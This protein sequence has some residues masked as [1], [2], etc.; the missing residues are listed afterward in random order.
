[1]DTD[2]RLSEIYA[3][4][5][6]RNG[7]SQ[8]DIDRSQTKHKANQLVVANV[9]HRINMSSVGTTHVYYKTINW[10]SIDESSPP[11]INTHVLICMKHHYGPIDVWHDCGRC[12]DD[13]NPIDSAVDFD[14]AT[15]K[16]VRENQDRWAYDHFPLRLVSSWG[17]DNVCIQFHYKLDM[18]VD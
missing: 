14:E 13:A 12:N 18:D 5:D 2:Q 17:R 15:A 7:W 6:R 3:E 16:W 9:N 4:I 11:L 10:G 8:A 1:M